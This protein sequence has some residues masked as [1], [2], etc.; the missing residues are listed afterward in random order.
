[1]KH[2]ANPVHPGGE[3]VKPMIAVIWRNTLAASGL[4]SLI[5]EVMPVAEVAV[6]SSLDDVAPSER[7]AYF[8]FFVSTATL[9]EHRDFFAAHAMKTIVV[10]EGPRPSSIP[11]AFPTID[12]TLDS[13][14]LL[15]QFI[16]LEQAA[17]AG[18]ARLPKGIRERAERKMN[19]AAL[20]PRETEVLREIV[21]GNIN[22]QIADHLNISITTVITHRKN[23]MEKLRAKSVATLTI[24]AV[25]HGIVSPEQ[26]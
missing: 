13:R 24:Y 14:S 5:E 18:G 22:K 19:A 3:G 2:P 23:I 1:M 10:T 20:T 16:R 4:A 17:H 12:A 7:E 11:R 9:L 26:I 15:R 6:F 25:M 8:H 21:M